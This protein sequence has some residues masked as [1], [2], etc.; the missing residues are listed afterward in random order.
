MVNAFEPFGKFR[1][2]VDISAIAALGSSKLTFVAFDP[3][4][5]GQLPQ[6]ETYPSCDL[7]LAAGSQL[8]A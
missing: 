6:I 5:I 4:A 3:Q 7:R 2:G 1:L 8:P